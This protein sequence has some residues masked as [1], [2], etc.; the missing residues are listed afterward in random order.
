MET[1]K[2]I[3]YI[4]LVLMPGLAL[5]NLRQERV[6]SEFKA[7]IKN[8]DPKDVGDLKTKVAVLDSRGSQIAAELTKLDQLIET[9]NEIKVSIA[10]LKK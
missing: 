1:S 5:W 4:L 10:E 3:D 7:Y 8:L 2:V 9:V 6:I